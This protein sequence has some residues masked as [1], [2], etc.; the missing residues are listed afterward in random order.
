[1]QCLTPGK[2]VIVEGSE[3]FNHG[4]AAA[5]VSNTAPGAIPNVVAAPPPPEGQAKFCTGCG[6]RI[7]PEDSFCPG[8]GQKNQA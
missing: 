5:A 8:C 7:S 3:Y 6:A 4:T 2:K 1:M